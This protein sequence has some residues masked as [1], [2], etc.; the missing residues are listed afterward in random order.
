MATSLS[1]NHP[2]IEKSSID[3]Y[4]AYAGAA[5][6]ITTDNWDCGVQCSR[7][8][9]EGTVIKYRW[10]IPFV[11]SNGYVALNSGRKVIVVAFRGSAEFGDWIEDF[12]TSFVDWPRSGAGT[13]VGRGFLEG[14][15]IASPLIIRTVL[16]LATTYPEYEIIATGHSLG[17]ARAA[18]FVADVSEN[19]TNILPRL[20]LYTY[21]QPKC[22]D[23]GF[24]DY[25][26]SL[27]ILKI[28]EINKADIAP[29][30]PT[31]D[32]G[33]HHFG[34][35]VW[36]TED[37]QYLVCQIEKLLDLVGITIGA[38]FNIDL[39]RLLKGRPTLSLDEVS[40]KLGIYGE[41]LKLYAA[42]SGASLN[43]TSNAWNCGVQCNH[44]ETRGTEVIY[45]WDNHRIATNGY[46]AVNHRR[47]EI[48]VVYRG[49]VVAADW[50]EDF[51]ANLAVWPES[52]PGS[53]V[54]TGFLQ[55][56]QAANPQ[57]MDTVIG[58]VRQ[59]PQYQITATGHS[60][61][62]AR[63]SLFVADVANRYPELISRMQLYTYGQPRCGNPDFARYMESLGIPYIRL[64]N[65]GDMFVHLPIKTLGYVHFGTEV[66]MLKDG[67]YVICHSDDYSKCSETLPLPRL[68]ADEH[69][70]YEWLLD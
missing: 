69:Y 49:S 42:Y 27:D 20:R 36:V 48:I 18:M 54:S 56:Y 66:W 63:A 24:A 7:S 26:D 6:L 53:R 65:K 17:G 30:L 12:T 51:T 41:N 52:V 45:H 46:I 25:M 23:K 2:G 34:T 31:A 37:N 10:S 47:R 4:A 67:E 57:A 61:G 70:Q 15:R 39:L 28:R 13:Q 68:N 64:I 19:H 38:N 40:H 9:T 3:L 16:E 44:P 50:V 55:G 32:S 1:V 29:H 11:T 8:G 21:G 59:Y 62:G 22:G 43:I 14:Y 58:L 5:Y 35:E 60:L 33:Y